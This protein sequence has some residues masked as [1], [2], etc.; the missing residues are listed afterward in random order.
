MKS[1]AAGCG[2]ISVAI[3]SIILLC[4]SSIMMMMMMIIII[5]IMMIIIIIIVKF[6]F[7]VNCII[8]YTEILT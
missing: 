5:I 1:K 6:L 3:S 4:I 8:T 7:N 2:S